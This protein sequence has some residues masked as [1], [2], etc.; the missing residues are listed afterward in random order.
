MNITALREMYHL[1]KGVMVLTWKLS[2]RFDQ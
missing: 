1:L 2:S